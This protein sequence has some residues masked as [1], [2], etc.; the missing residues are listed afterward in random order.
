MRNSLGSN[1]SVREGDSP[2]LATGAHGLD[3][4]VSRS[5]RSW[6]I[7]RWLALHAVSRNQYDPA[8]IAKRNG[9]RVDPAVESLQSLFQVLEPVTTQKDPA[10]AVG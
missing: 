4:K 8:K 1:A 5:A 10:E 3:D 7:F 9:S 2:P 6:L